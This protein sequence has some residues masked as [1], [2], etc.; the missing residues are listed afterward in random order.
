MYT[1][2]STDL[3]D[4]YILEWEKD[5]ETFVMT[6]ATKFVLDNISTESCIAVVGC[7]GSGKSA[8]IHQVALHLR[9]TLQ[10][11]IIPSITEPSDLKQYYNSSKKQIFILDDVFGSITVNGPVVDKW[12]LNLEMIERIISL[13]K[14]KVLISCRLQ[15]I[16]DPLLCR[17]KILTANQLNLHSEKLCLIK[18]ERLAIAQKYLEKSDIGHI[19][20]FLETY[21]FFPLLCKYFSKNVNSDPRQF[22]QNPVEVMKKHII[23]MKKETN[24]T[25]Y[26]AFTLCVLFNN[27]LKDSWLERD[28]ENDNVIRRV[29][30]DVG[31]ELNINRRNLQQQLH[32]LENTNVHK[33]D[34]SYSIIHDKIFDVAGAICGQ[35][36]L[37]C[38]IKNADATFIGDR[39]HME[40]L[41]TKCNENYIIHVPESHEKMYFVRLMTDLDRGNTYSTFQNRQLQFTQ[42][43]EKLIAFIST[44]RNIT[45]EIILTFDQRRNIEDKQREEECYYS[46]TSDDDDTFEQ[47]SCTI[48]PEDI[49]KDIPLPLLE[50]SSQG[51]TD[52]VNMLINMGCNV[53]IRDSFGRSAMYVAALHGHIATVKYLL[54]HRSDVLQCDRWG[55]SSLYIACEEGHAEVVQLLL[56]DSDV[57]KCDTC[58]FKSPLH[59]ACEKGHA[60]IVK[61]LLENGSNLDQCNSDGHSPLYVAC[62]SGYPKLVKLLIGFGSDINQTDEKDSTPLYIS[63][64]NGHSKVVKLLLGKRADVSLCDSD[65]LSPLHI[66]CK[67]GH[68]AVVEILLESNAEMDTL[69]RL[70]GRTPLFLACEGKHEEII[71]LLIGKGCNINHCNK[72]KQSPL[73]IACKTGQTNVVKLFLQQMT[74]HYV[75]SFNYCD[76]SP[77]IAA[78]EVGNACIV[79]MLLDR[80]FYIN[81]RNENDQRPLHIAC[82]L[83]QSDIV[84][85]LLRYEC[86]LN[87]LDGQG[88]SP[89]FIACEEGFAVIVK[90]LLENNAE[91]Q[92]NENGWSPFFIACLE[93]HAD[94]VELLFQYQSETWECDNDT[95]RSPLFVA[96]KERNIDVVDL[97]LQN[98][99]N[100]NQVDISK[101]SPLHI[102][103]KEGHTDVVKLLLKSG[104][105]ATLC[106]NSGRRPVDLARSSFRDS[107]VK[108]LELEYP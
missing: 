49:D 3:I 5:E 79:Q 17:L 91:L 56:T 24:R 38:F 40:F 20:D 93:G 75:L 2:L 16:K 106:T 100:V 105:D 7:P 68:T 102:A 87:L 71:Q 13:G 50:S 55:R 33:S 101:W 9:K 70:Y 88:L 89:L 81:I 86:D 104:A 15:I 61:M 18:E 34:G 76:W 35:D 36:L 108:L 53:N 4:S 27:K 12:A 78:C 42:Y 45:E 58:Y 82:K 65:G 103:S 96:C 59:V 8:I 10:Y 72:R 94:V 28:A 51:F 90:L 21:A 64:K 83:G 77:L 69:D 43:R 6:R 73:Y 54:Q 1:F 31:L 29:C 25:Q 47:S 39:Y 52:I 11:E 95:M 30:E 26:C 19:S 62:S 99:A 60:S 41:T 74:D 98:K 97:L 92:T 44:N 85:V 48:H 107:V 57:S 23:D 63:C 46:S 67:W 80:N 66:S 22:F 84:K 32:N 37:E 14:T